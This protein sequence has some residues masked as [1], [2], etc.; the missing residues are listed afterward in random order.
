MAQWALRINQEKNK[1]K[2]KKY[3][4]SEKQMTE[5]QYCRGAKNQWVP[6]SMNGHPV[7]N[8]GKGAFGQDHRSQVKN[9]EGKM[10]WEKKT[11]I[12]MS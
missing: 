9:R 6:E 7:E 1:G 10:V 8:K 3:Y 4:I 11:H 2:E 12:A 5:Y